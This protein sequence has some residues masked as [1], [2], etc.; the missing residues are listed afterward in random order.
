[1]ELT[2]EFTHV[3]HKEKTVSYS[4]NEII[5]INKLDPHI[6]SLRGKSSL[7]NREICLRLLTQIIKS[8]RW[9]L[10]GTYGPYKVITSGYRQFKRIELS[11]SGKSIK[12]CDI[13]NNL[14]AL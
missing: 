5:R 8:N 1:M 2:Q 14:I 11:E 6:H 7:A 3:T 13:Y 4:L 12:A 9:K 10:F